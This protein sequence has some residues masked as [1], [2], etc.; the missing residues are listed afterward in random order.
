MESSQ[1]VDE[2]QVAIVVDGYKPRGQERRV[3]RH[4]TMDR[5]GRKTQQA[6]D[7]GVVHSNA[8]PRP[9]QILEERVDHRSHQD[10]VRRC[11]NNSRI[12]V[13]VRDR[14]VV[15]ARCRRRL[16]VRSGRTCLAASKPILKAVPTRCHTRSGMSLSR[17]PRVS[18][19]AAWSSLPQPVRKAQ[20]VLMLTEP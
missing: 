17:N 14:R 5:G 18:T 7:K 1:P 13:S 8:A 10:P 12:A 9:V 4:A 20:L 15:L 19:R 16:A 6:R 3:G 11:S 2:S